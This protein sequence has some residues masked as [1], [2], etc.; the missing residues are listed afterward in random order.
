MS[1]AVLGLCWPQLKLHQVPETLSSL[2][3]HYKL[4]L[5]HSL[6]NTAATIKQGI[7]QTFRGGREGKLKILIR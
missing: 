3:A 2:W 1:T 4:Q 5:T 7:D 6:T